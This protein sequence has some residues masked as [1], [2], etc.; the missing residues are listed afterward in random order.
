MALAGVPEKHIMRVA[1]HK[2][3]AMLQRYNITVEQDTFNTLARTQEYLQRT[4]PSPILKNQGESGKHEVP[5][6]P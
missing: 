1:G 3:T 4:Q 5:I 6:S 2:T